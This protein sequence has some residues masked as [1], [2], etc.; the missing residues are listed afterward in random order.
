MAKFRPYLSVLLVLV[1]ML[2]LAPAVILVPDVAAAED[3]VQEVEAT[4]CFTEDSPG[5]DW[6]TFTAGSGGVQPPGLC[7]EQFTRQ[8]V[9][10]PDAV[11]DP[12]VPGCGFRNYT[13]AS[14]GTISGDLS[15]SLSLAWITFRFNQTYNHTPKYNVTAANGTNFG[16]MSGRG[17]IGEDLT[18]V[19]IADLDCNDDMTNAIGKGVMVSTEESGAFTGHKVIGDFEVEK[20]GVNYTWNLHL[21]N[22]APNE[23]YYRG[24]VTVEGGVMQENTDAIGMPLELLNFTADGSVVTPSDV[25]TDFEEIAWGKDP[26]KTVTGGPLGADG[27]MDIS[28]NGALYLHIVTEEGAVYIQATECCRL[29][30]D[31]TYSVTGND[32]SMYGHAY[33]YLVLSLPYQE[34]PLG[35]FFSQ[36]GY[37]WGPFGQ[38]N[39]STNCYAGAETYALAHIDI[40]SSIGLSQ[41][42]SVDE[43][44]GLYP[45]P[46]VD[47]VVPGVGSPNTMMNVT[48]KG[49]Y[50]L[51]AD[52]EKSGWVANA[53]SLSFGEGITVNS[54]TIKNGSEIDNEIE[55]NI[56]ISACAAGPRDVSVTSCFGYTH[57]HGKEPYKT[58]SLSDGFD[59]PV[60]GD[61]CLE[62]HVDF[63][64]ARGGAAPND[65]WIE[66]FEVHLF[67]AGGA[68][69]GCSPV[70]AT[71][72]DTGVFR[73]WGIPPGTYNISVK[74]WTCLR[75]VK[76]GE[77]LLVDVPNVVDF[78]TLLQGDADNNNYVVM[79][80]L[81]AML[82]AWNKQVGDPEYSVKFDFNRDGYVTMADLG[83]MLPN[84]NGAGAPALT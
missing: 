76:L 40:E 11:P 35:Q 57:G 29:H 69:L 43:S 23:V 37:T 80:D 65:K 61:A 74:N 39:P 73:I 5:G 10:F 50:F 14:G 83:V 1:M 13:S 67:V 32:N 17:H 42:Y 70:T 56:T 9:L 71:T 44:Y 48:I 46:K 82:P 41:Q 62:G 66:P 72:N 64:L 4:F 75:E 54:Y 33:Y 18:F 26:V 15:G 27:D 7:L 45:H 28:R 12:A 38:I 19:F 36:D 47:A 77:T 78:G 60:A 30:I 81:G 49:K 24:I 53:G 22:Y 8:Y 3:V 2:F 84:W 63:G 34:L 16:F 25:T 52:G 6:H 68:E 58:G 20:I 59:V 31:D 51:R 21:R 79:A 55:A